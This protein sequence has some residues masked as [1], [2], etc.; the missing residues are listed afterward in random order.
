M[1]HGSIL[2]PK[3]LNSPKLLILNLN[4]RK[5]TIVAVS[6]ELQNPK[7]QKHIPIRIPTNPKRPPPA[8]ALGS[9]GLLWG[10]LMYTR[11]G[12][13]IRGTLGGV[14]LLN[15][16]PVQESQKRVKKGSLFGVPLILPRKEGHR[17]LDACVWAGAALDLMP[18]I[19]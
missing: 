3:A 19:I 12:N 11:L 14:D 15:K 4:P 2:L 6:Q 16:V 17:I 1:Q 9:S 18:E 8:P 5:I 10:L 13:R 7:I